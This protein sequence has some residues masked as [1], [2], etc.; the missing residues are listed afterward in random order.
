MD[1]A[2]TSTGWQTPER[3]KKLEREPI[4]PCMTVGY[5]LINRP[6]RIVVCSTVS[7]DRDLAEV[8]VIPRGA[9]K[10]IKRLEPTRRKS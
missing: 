4:C 3:V 10:R 1:I 9:V 5:L 6:D 8:T 2:T 7:L